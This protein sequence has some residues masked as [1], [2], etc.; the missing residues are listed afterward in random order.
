MNTELILQFGTNN[1]NRVRKIDLLKEMITM[2]E[3]C[4]NM[5]IYVH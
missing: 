4:E 5:I 1:F 2:S 3:V